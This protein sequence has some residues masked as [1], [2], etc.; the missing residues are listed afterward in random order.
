MG[1]DPEVNING[2]PAMRKGDEYADGRTLAEGSSGVF[3]NGKPAGRIG[4]ALSGGGLAMTGSSSVYIGEQRAADLLAGIGIG[5]T[6]CQA[7]QADQSLPTTK[8]D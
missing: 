8:V 5:S 2:R 6:P 3:I 1:G 4:D 7:A